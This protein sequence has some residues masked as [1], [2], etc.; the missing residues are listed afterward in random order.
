MVEAAGGVNGWFVAG[1]AAAAPA[2][3]AFCDVA[4]AAL[5]AAGPFAVFTAAGRARV[6][7]VRGAYED[8]A[9]KAT[10]EANWEDMGKLNGPLTCGFLRAT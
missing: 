5:D 1:P 9:R 6:A 2:A 7:A 10:R 4:G 3:A 8:A